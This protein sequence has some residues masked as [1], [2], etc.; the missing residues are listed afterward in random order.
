MPHGIAQC[1]LPPGRGDIPAL[2]PGEAGT[3][4]Q[5]PTWSA[6]VFQQAEDAVDGGVGKH[7]DA[8]D[9]E[10][11]VE[12]IEHCGDMLLTGLVYFLAGRVLD[13]HGPQSAEQRL[14]TTADVGRTRFNQLTD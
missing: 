12:H 6:D 3:R 8:V 5:K 7:D 4:C 2:A 9:S 1:Y 14:P 11:D 13:L 10:E